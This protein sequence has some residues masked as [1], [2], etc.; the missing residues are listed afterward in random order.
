MFLYW[1]LAST[2]NYERYFFVKLAE[3]MSPVEL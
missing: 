3:Q 2:I 1:S